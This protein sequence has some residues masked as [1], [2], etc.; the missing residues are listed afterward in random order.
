[1]NLSALQFAQHRLAEDVAETLTATGLPASQLCLEIT[2]TVLMSD[3]V[4]TV[5]TLDELHDLGVAVAIDDFGTGYSS[6]SYL[7]RFAI[8]VVKLDR[9]FIE[10]LVTD[11]VDVEIASAVIRL[12]EAL[13]MSTVAEGVETD[14]QRQM[15]VKLGCPFIQGYLTSRPLA[16]AD[17]LEFWA[18]TYP[19]APAP[20]PTAQVERDQRRAS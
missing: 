8:D 1:M 12:T 20:S 9:T 15:L 14:S 2:E 7:K 18:S 17:F 10:G 16:A 3:T 4:G 6:L 19:E 11:A 5:T 13:H